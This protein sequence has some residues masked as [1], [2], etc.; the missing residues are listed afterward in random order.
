MNEEVLG[1]I[2]QDI[3]LVRTLNNSDDINERMRAAERLVTNGYYLA[4]LKSDAYDEF[5][6]L[7]TE[8]ENAVA[9]DET[10][11]TG[12]ATKAKAYAKSK[13]EALN[14]KLAKAKGLY[15]RLESLLSQ[16]NAVVEQIRQT[17]SILKTERRNNGY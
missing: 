8:Y 17:L 5:T 11:N 7:E 15:K 1:Q 4:G 3:Q 14:V 16:S 10:N 2:F 13:N 9:F 12:P 6:Q